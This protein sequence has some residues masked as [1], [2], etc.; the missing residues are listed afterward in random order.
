MERHWRREQTKQISR[1]V[2]GQERSRRQRQR[3][4]LRGREKVPDTEKAFPAP[5]L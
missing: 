1:E 4:K 5:C 3:E 2:G